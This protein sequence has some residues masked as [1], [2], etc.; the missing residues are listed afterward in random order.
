MIQSF[1]VH[2]DHQLSAANLTPNN[3]TRTAAFSLLF[4]KPTNVRLFLF[5]IIIIF[6]PLSLS[7]LLGILGFGGF[8]GKGNTI[9]SGNV[10]NKIASSEIEVY[11]VRGI[12][13]IFGH[14]MYWPCRSYT[15]L[16][17]SIPLQACTTKD[18][19]LL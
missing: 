3:N 5:G 1:K 9:P 15:D 10:S 11:D 14:G 18:A 17:C 7:S 19:P 6:F 16:T 4:A 8:G 13:R 2:T 12:G